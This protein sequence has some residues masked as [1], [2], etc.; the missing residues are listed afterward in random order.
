M[1]TTVSVIK[2]SVSNCYLVRQQGTILVDSGLSNETKA[3]REQLMALSVAPGELKLVV[4]THGH[5]DHTGGASFLKEWTGA[6]IA[7]HEKDREMAEQGL[8]SWSR[9]VTNYGRLSRLILKPIMKS[10]APPP[11]VKADIILGDEDYPLDE[12]G[13][14]GRIIHTPGH[15]P[16]SVSVVLDSGEAF[17]SCLAHNGLPLRLRPGLPIYADDIDKVRLSWNRIFDAGA[18][19]VYPAHG[20]PFPIE[21]AKRFLGR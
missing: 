13:I 12:F 16:G 18:K 4:L 6:R 3:F 7:I 17:V 9:G 8:F 21:V 5:Y 14:E 11:P 15:T 10:V 19:V 20:D 2:S 1:K